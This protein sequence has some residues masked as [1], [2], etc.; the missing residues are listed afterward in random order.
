[1]KYIIFL[2]NV[3]LSTCVFSMDNCMDNRK[4][5]IRNETH[6]LVTVSYNKVLPGRVQSKYEKIWPDKTA[7]LSLPATR[8]LCVHVPGYVV[9]KVYAFEYQTPV[10]IQHK[11]DSVVVTQGNE[12]LGVMKQV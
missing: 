6:K 11:K 5:S 7:E 3:L 2:T 9:Q 8:G 1:M 12:T 4:L 10:V